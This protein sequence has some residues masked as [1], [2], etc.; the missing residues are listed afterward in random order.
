MKSIPDF[1]GHS[2]SFVGSLHR[3]AFM[4]FLCFV[5]HKETRAQRNEE[6]EVTHLQNISAR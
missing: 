5:A 3:T 6:S 4:I 1:K 2:T